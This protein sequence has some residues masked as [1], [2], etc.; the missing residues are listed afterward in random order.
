MI[1]KSVLKTTI[2][3]LALLSAALVTPVYANWFSD[4][5]LNIARNVGSA[6]NPAPQDLREDRLALYP[7]LSRSLNEQGVKSLPI[8]TLV[9][10]PIMTP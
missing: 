6:P 5:A 2:L 8:A 4:P 3:P 10:R 1:P 9:S 7:Q